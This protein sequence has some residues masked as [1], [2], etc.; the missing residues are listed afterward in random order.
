MGSLEQ[1]IATLFVVLKD[2]Q[3]ASYGVAGTLT[4][5][6]YDI[7]V[8]FADEYEVI[9]KANWSWGKFLY[10]WSRYGTVCYQISLVMS[11]Q[12]I[13]TSLPFCEVVTRLQLWLAITCTLAMEIIQALRT[14]AI[15]GHNKRIQRT[16]YAYCFAQII[17]LTAITIKLSVSAIFITLPFKGGSCAFVEVLPKKYLVVLFAIALA[18]EVVLWVI[19]SFRI[20]QIIQGGQS[21]LAWIIFRDTLMYFPLNSALSLGEFLALLFMPVDHS[22]LLLV[23][24]GAWLSLMSIAIT[25]MVFHLREYMAGPPSVSVYTMATAGPQISSVVS[26]MG[27]AFAPSR[28]RDSD[29][30][31]NI[32]SQRTVEEN[33]EMNSYNYR[34]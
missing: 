9:W 22:L 13:G 25:R 27:I 18:Y 2:A 26:H 34:S 28:R 33:V 32:D 7:C 15:F 10:I 20:Y 21:K 14:A 19:G 17:V 8:F 24:D 6:L 5:I 16:I 12:L 1:E 11:T 30:L 23:V 29:I 3:I 4:L 31:D